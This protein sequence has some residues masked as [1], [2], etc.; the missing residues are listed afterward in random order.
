M[1][2]KFKSTKPQ[3]ENWKNN[4]EVILKAINSTGD[5]KIARAVANGMMRFSRNL[6]EMI[7]R[8]GHLNAVM[9]EKPLTAFD[10]IVIRLTLQVVAEELGHP[11]A[12]HWINMAEAK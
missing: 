10:D 6:V 1:S 12:V 8:N 11:I 4:R 9:L 3:V 7:K 2:K 5:S